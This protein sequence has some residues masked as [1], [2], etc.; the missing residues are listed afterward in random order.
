MNLSPEPI[1]D[2]VR[3]LSTI[4]SFGIVVT[5]MKNLWKELYNSKCATCD[6][7]GSM[8]CGHCHGT[9]MRR[10]APL[11]Y[12]NQD[13]NHPDNEY[14][15]YYC[16]D[17]APNDFKY[18]NL[19]D[20][21]ETLNIMANLKS[22][23]AN[24]PRPHP[25]R[26]MAGTVPCPSCDGQAVIYRHTPDFSKVFNLEPPWPLHVGFRSHVEKQ[27]RPRTKYIEYPIGPPPP[28]RKIEKPKPK[29]RGLEGR[30]L[31]EVVLPF[32]DDSDTEDEEM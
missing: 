5:Q 12:K 14:D 25:H 30:A 16:G 23:M 24:K 32:I 15:C 17:Y 29:I 20:D 7:A 6:G 1:L 13:Y 10:S 4:A 2:I 19:P 3:G 9:K 21:T 28:L 27:K 26:A 31:D 11:R 8:I 22:A 18:E